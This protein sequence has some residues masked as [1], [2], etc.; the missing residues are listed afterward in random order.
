MNYYNRDKLFDLIQDNSIALLA[1][2]KSSEQDDTDNDL[3]FRQES[4]FH[5]LF[6]VNE[7]DYYGILDFSNRKSILFVPDRDD[8]YPIWHGYVHPLAYYSERYNV[9]DVK[10]VSELS[11]WIQKRNPERIQIIGTPNP[12]TKKTLPEPTFDGIEK[13]R[14]LIRRDI[15]YH[16]ISDCRVIKTKLEIEHLK[17]LNDISSQAHIQLMQECHVGMTEFQ[18]QSIFNHYCLYVLVLVLILRYCI[19][20]TIIK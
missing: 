14:H 9:S 3:H 18:L 8:M 15:L 12:N 17:K 11:K 5:Y 16:K 1:G 7:P 19:I 10:H 4:N 20:P 13:F 6:G 2:N